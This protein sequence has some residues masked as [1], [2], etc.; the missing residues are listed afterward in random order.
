VRLHNLISLIG[1]KPVKILLRGERIISPW[2][3]GNQGLL[4]DIHFTDAL[5]I[6]GLINSHDHLDFNC[7]NP[8]GH[9][10][11]ENYR[12]WGRFIHRHF[13]Q[14]IRQV[15]QIPEKL[16]TRWGIYKNLLAGVTTVVNHGQRLKID[17]PLITVYQESQNLHSVG[18][19]RFWKWKLNN[20]V[21]RKKICVIHTGEGRDETAREEIDELLRLNLI[22]REIVGVHGLAMQAD[23]AS[24]FKGL[25][26]CPESNRILFSRQ[27]PIERLKKNTTV[28]LGTDSTLTGRWNIWQHLR[29]ARSLQ[30]TGDWELFDMVTRSAALLWGM[31]SGE[32]KPGRYADLVVLK[33]KKNLSAWDSLYMSN[34][35]DILLVVHRG[36][37]RLFDHTLMEQLE[38][39]LHAPYSRVLI[40]KDVKYVEGDLPQLIARIKDYHPEIRFPAED[41]ESAISVS[42]D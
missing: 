25:V 32:L 39:R 9:R 42:H 35:E 16:R 29:Y 7:F 18:F 8:L 17:Q 21:H 13:K 28:V 11:Y 2:E 14:E 36:R 4:P 31:E 40:D 10:K 26:W 33:K 38:G 1:H 20:P 6:P 19:E 15:L 34:P 24:R 23:Q 5:V 3:K 27:A 30:K 41:F 37:I 22:G 12:E